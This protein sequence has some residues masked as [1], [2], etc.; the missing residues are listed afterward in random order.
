MVLGA[1]DHAHGLEADGLVRVANPHKH[2]HPL[3]LQPELGTRLAPAVNKK[4]T[5]GQEIVYMTSHLCGTRGGG[6]YFHARNSPSSP[7]KYHHMK[8]A[9]TRNEDD[10]RDIYS[11]F[12]VGR[13]NQAEPS[14]RGAIPG[15]VQPIAHRQHRAMRRRKDIDNRKLPGVQRQSF[16]ASTLQNAKYDMHPVY[17]LCVETLAPN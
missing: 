7:V 5:Q 2:H 13:Q 9:T 4:A 16:I 3:L 12:R 8:I 6:E 11:V 10:I 15:P 1:P 14:C 17:L